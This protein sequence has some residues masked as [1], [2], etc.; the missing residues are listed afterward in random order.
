MK[1]EVLRVWECGFYSKMGF[2]L[3]LGSGVVIYLFSWA[4]Y[5]GFWLLGL[6]SLMGVVLLYSRVDVECLSELVCRRGLRISLVVISMWVGGLSYACT[7]MYKMK[8]ERFF[9]VSLFVLI[10]VSVIFFMVGNWL[11]IYFFFESSL[12]PILVLILGWGYQPERLQAA[13]FMLIYTVRAS[14]PLLVVLVYLMYGNGRI[15]LFV[16]CYYVIEHDWF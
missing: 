12:I 9:R 6:G 1:K 10:V 7:F 3:I 4:F 11:L 14:L 16:N 15:S 2:V 5:L 8:F 13:R